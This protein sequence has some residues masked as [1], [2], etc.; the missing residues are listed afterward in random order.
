MSTPRSA[1][2]PPRAF[3]RLQGPPRITVVPALPRN[4]GGKV[5]KSRLEHRRTEP[6]PP[7]WPGEQPH[8]A[9]RE[10][11][12]RV[13]PDPQP[14][15]TPQPADATLHPGDPGRRGGG[16]SRPRHR[17]SRHP[18]HGAFVLIGLRDTSRKTRS[19]GLRAARGDRGRRVGH[20]RAG[21]RMGRIWDCAIPVI[22]QVHGNC[23]AGGTDLA[24]HC[25][26]VVAADD[27]RF[28]FP[29]VRSM[30][31]PPTN[32]W[33]YHLGPQWTKRLVF[34]GDTLTGPRRSSRA[35]GGDGAG[36]RARRGGP[37]PGRADGADRSRP[38]R[39]EQTG[40]EHGCRAD[41][42]LAAAAIRRAR[43]TPS[44]T[45]ARG[46][47][48]LEADRRS[49]AAPGGQGPDAPFGAPAPDEGSG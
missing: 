47:G 44:A 18:R 1:P 39:G 45:A 24:L 37:R 38:A 12:A 27:A 23:L 16:R 34:T 30:G 5:L 41:G 10:D 33:L 29:P 11:R 31:V 40:R 46:Q 7:P 25:D 28:G 26:I 22:A 19:P 9:R 17:A 2:V 32:M 6:R 4:A 36:R 14:A 20:A 43:T 15:R 3:G 35:G 21:G 13:P 42:P 48:L 8:A 49:G